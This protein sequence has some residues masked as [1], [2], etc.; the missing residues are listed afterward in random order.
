MDRPNVFIKIPGTPAGV[1]AIR[2]ATAAGI[3]V[4]V[5]LL[6]SVEAY[7]QV[8][9]VFLSGLEER[10]KRGESVRDGVSVASFFVS[11]VDTAIDP[12]LAEAGREDLAGRA[13]IANARIAYA[14]FRELVAGERI[15]ALSKH[16]A[17]VQRPLWAST[18]V[19]DERYPDER[20]IEAGD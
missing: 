11:R 15:A 14:R 12:M 1:E 7:M 6:F 4:N 2:R 10:V 18:G 17:R 16:G 20:G 9:D 8:A 19:K 3:N 5:T 13:G